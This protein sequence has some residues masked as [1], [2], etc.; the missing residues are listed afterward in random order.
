MLAEVPA[1]MLSVPVGAI[2]VRGVEAAVP[3]TEHPPLLR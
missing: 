1:K 3:V 2:D